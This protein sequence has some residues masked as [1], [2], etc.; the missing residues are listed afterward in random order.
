MDVDFYLERVNE[1]DA[2]AD[3]DVACND[4]DEVPAGDDPVAVAPGDVG[5]G[6][7]AGE[8]EEFVSEGVEDG[9]ELAGAVVF[10]GNVAV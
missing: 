1:E 3:T 10:A 9:A 5:E 8:H 2:D 7:E 6:D 4:H